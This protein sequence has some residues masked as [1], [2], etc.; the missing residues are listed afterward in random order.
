MLVGL[1]FSSSHMRDA[2]GLGP[3]DQL[4]ICV[5]RVDFGLLDY[6]MAWR[7]YSLCTFGPFVFIAHPLLKIENR[8]N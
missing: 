8:D 3:S 4:P 5:G 1:K 7:D 2:K 6:I